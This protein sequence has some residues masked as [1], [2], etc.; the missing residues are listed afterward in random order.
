MTGGG[1]SEKS[2]RF[3]FLKAGSFPNLLFSNNDSSTEVHEESL[4]ELQKQ[5]ARAREGLEHIRFFFCFMALFFL[6]YF[7]T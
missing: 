2:Q 1:G 6:L 5:S 4:F 3:T 7:M